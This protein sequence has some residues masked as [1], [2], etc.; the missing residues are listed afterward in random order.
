[1]PG[2]I[3]PMAKRLYASAYAIGDYTGCPIIAALSVRLCAA[4]RLLSGFYYAGCA[5]IMC[6]LLAHPYPGHAMLRCPV[7]LSPAICQAT[8]PIPRHM[9]AA[10]AARRYAG[11][12]HNI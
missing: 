3:A 11:A 7:M 12:T 2:Y 6:R 9:S 8:R 1:M 5:I 4:M 10:I